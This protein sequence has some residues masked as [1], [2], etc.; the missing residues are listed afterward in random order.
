VYRV[1]QF[2]TGANNGSTFADGFTTLDAALAAASNPGDQIWVARGLYT[3]A[4]TT[5]TA[6]F[7]VPSGVEVYGGF[8][9]NDSLETEVELRLG[10]AT[11]T[12]LSGEIQGDGN[13]GNNSYHVVSATAGDDETLLDSLT[14]QEGAASITPLL[15]G[16][17]AKGGGIYAVG[18][19]L[20]L[21]RCIIK[22]N[23]ATFGGGVYFEGQT[24]QEVGD[25]FR[26][27]NCRFTS[28]D[29]RRRGGAIEFAALGVP[30][31][32]S[33]GFEH[34]TQLVEPSWIYS[35]TF[36]RNRGGV[37]DFEADPEGTNLTARGG[38]TINVE[39]RIA[40][41][42]GTNGREQYYSLQVVNCE[43]RENLADGVGTSMR[44]V[45]VDTATDNGGRIFVENTTMAGDTL[46]GAAVIASIE[47]GTIYL[48]GPETAPDPLIPRQTRTTVLSATI[49]MAP[50][51]NPASS[52]TTDAIAGGAGAL[53]TGPPQ[54]PV[55]PTALTAGSCNIQQAFGASF[56]SNINEDP[57]F[58]NFAFRDYRLTPG[59][60]SEN[61][62]VP[63]MTALLAKDFPNLDDDPLTFTLPIDIAGVDRVI[64]GSVDQGCHELD[65]TVR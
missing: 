27:V 42:G 41:L 45:P 57:M 55:E 5:P 3:P 37:L 30:S 26:A 54:S 1:N 34:P 48:M 25:G 24:G 58:V 52:S 23:R 29:A 56:V 10:D 18:T 50:N 47:P 33:A 17:D 39:R 16:N 12:I 11:Q 7:T 32:A 19:D 62:G 44:I 51:S 43:F 28:N 46:T 63:S 65:D 59:S 8:L 15:S 61:T 49:V 4:G 20:R 14:I 9:G 31:E 21:D 6:T 22:D 35:C 64:D 13:I 40:R 53:A 2:A 38:G 36:D 60:P